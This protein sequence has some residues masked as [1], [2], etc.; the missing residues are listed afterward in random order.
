M[1]LALAI[2]SLAFVLVTLA[3]ATFDTNADGADGRQTL[4]PQ[5][6]GDPN[7]R[8]TVAPLA[9]RLAGH[10][11]SGVRRPE[12]TVWISGQ[13]GRTGNVWGAG[14]EE[15]ARIA[16]ENLE[17]ELERAGGSLENVVEL[18]SYHR[19]LDALEEFRAVKGSV[20]GSREVAWTAVEV[21][22]FVERESLLEIK[23]TAVIP[24]VR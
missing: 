4:R 6:V 10:D 3:A 12:R 21:A 15:Q 1:R 22:D 8:G 24:S 13:M 19:D 16:F 23:A 2:V 5:R 17:A 20:F 11:V 7:G 14:P 18:T 9:L